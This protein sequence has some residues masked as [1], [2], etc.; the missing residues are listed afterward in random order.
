MKKGLHDTIW[1]FSIGKK[2]FLTKAEAI[3]KAERCQIPTI[4]PSEL[5]IV[6]GKG[7]EYT[8]ECDVQVNGFCRQGR[9]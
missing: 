8:R 9:R 3:A 7:F 2:A 1:D 5:E 6:D 4:E